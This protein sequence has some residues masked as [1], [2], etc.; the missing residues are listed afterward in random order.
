[1]TGCDIIPLSKACSGKCAGDCTRTSHTWVMAACEGM[2]ALFEKHADG[3]LE[4]LPRS[5]GD[6]VHSVDRLRA[7]LADVSLGG[8]TPQLVLVGSANDIAWT[9]ALLPETIA[10]HIIAEIQY[11]LVNG[12]F[13]GSPDLR[14]L[15][16]ALEQV[17]TH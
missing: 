9:E 6:S 12:W 10:K 5:E 4:L 13:R 2:I 17:L 1:M 16:H 3:H 7:C 11:P 8:S 15:S 14:Q